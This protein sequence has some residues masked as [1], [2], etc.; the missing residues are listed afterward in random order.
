MKEKKKKKD[1]INKLLKKYSPE[2]VCQI[3]EIEKTT[4]TTILKE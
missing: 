1:I 4:L 2:E 3:L